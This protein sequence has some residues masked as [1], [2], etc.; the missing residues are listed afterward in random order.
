[1]KISDMKAG[2]NVRGKRICLNEGWKYSG[3][4]ASV[5]SSAMAALSDVQILSH[6]LNTTSPPPS[7]LN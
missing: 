3:D 6:T 5:L 4:P 1:M 7:L 2:T